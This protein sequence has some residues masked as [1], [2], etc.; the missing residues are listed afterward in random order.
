MEKSKFAINLGK[1]RREKGL[2]QRQ[3]SLELGISQALLSH[4]ENDARE[5]KLEFV[6][7]ISDYY[8]V[9][10]DYILGQTKE[11]QDGATRL[12]AQV[13]EIVNSLEEI[14]KKEA[15]LIKKL[16]SLTSLPDKGLET[17]EK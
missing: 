16:T 8:N 17:N 13:N 15:D 6:I 7:K 9:T 11:R 5:P 12:S 2:S 10:T 14:R 1:L 4:Y 3:A